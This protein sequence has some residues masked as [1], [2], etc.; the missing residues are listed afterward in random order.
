[1]EHPPVLQTT[2]PLSVSLGDGLRLPNDS[3]QAFLSDAREAL[4]ALTQPAWSNYTGWIDYPEQLEREL[5][6]DIKETALSLTSQVQRI[7]CIGVGGSALGAKAILSAL[8]HPFAPTKESGC[9]ILFAGDQL[10]PDYLANLKAYLEGSPFA[11]VYVSKSGHTIEPAITFHTLCEQLYHSVGATKARECIVLITDEKKGSLN[12]LAIERGYR[13]LPIP[14]TIGGRFSTLTAVGLLPAALVGIDIKA[15][16]EGASTMHKLL[17]AQATALEENP[18][19]L[20]AATRQYLYQQKGKKIE[21]LATFDP[22]LAFLGK[23]WEQ[24]FAESEGKNG[25]GLFPVSTLYTTDLHALGQ[26]VQ[27]GERTIFETVVQYKKKNRTLALNE[28][29]I[30]LGAMRFL[31][32]VPIADI[33]EAALSGTKEAHQSGGVPIITIEMVQKDAFHLGALLY[34]FEVAVAVSGLMMGINP[35]DQ[36]GVEAYKSNMYRQLHKPSNP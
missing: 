5:L 19:L 34:F 16:L 4:L 1:M 8:G 11:L 12:E 9:E 3:L 31:A 29:I 17:F 14:T 22:Q 20:Y 25:K 30:S 2:P 36:P 27:E 28:G 13:T 18:A 10:C 6:N 23:W 7:V 15:L 26:W 32:G 35:F 24:L 33:E 21:L